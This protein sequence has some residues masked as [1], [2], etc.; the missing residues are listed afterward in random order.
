VARVG[1]QGQAAER[2]IVSL[3]SSLVDS[4]HL[5]DSHPSDREAE[6]VKR[7]VSGET[8]SEIGV[9][10]DKSPAVVRT[11]LHRAAIRELISRGFDK[12]LARHLVSRGIGGRERSKVP[13]DC[14]GCGTAGRAL[15]LVVEGIYVCRECSGDAVLPWDCG[16]P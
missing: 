11:I 13:R 2:V 7:R 12:E 16:G 1:G 5:V 10:I 4:Q 14:A 9:H 15:F 6:V 3:D 8:L